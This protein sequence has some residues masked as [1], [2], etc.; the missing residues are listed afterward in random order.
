MIVGETFTHEG[1][2]YTATSVD[3]TSIKAVAEVDVQVNDDIT[4]KQ[5]ER[6]CIEEGD[7]SA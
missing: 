3:G 7:I 4:T 6:I 1:I 5:I 2:E